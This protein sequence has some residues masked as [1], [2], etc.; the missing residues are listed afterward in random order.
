MSSMSQLPP[1]VSYVQ[2]FGVPIVLAVIAVFGAWIA[3]CQM[4]IARERLRLDAFD[5]VY[6]RRVAI[7]EATRKFLGD[8]F[9][10]MSKE[11]ISAYGLCTLDAE[12]LF[13]ENMYDYLREI[14]S[15]VTIWHHAKTKGEQEAHTDE[16]EADQLSW[17]TQ[18]GDRRFPLRFATFLV[19]RPAKHPWYLRWLPILDV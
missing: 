7:Y 4:W 13:N 19:Y 18:Q 2:A 5:R 10:N 17:I 14:L 9:D 3:A 8:V 6:N 12:F 15:R 11:K 1:W 16:K